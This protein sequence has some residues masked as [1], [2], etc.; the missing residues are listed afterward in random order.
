MQQI[1]AS[2]LT[3]SAKVFPFWFKCRLAVKDLIRYM[4]NRGFVKCN[5]NI[6]ETKT[7]QIC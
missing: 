7:R 1:V 4:G 2:L 3:T 5:M 6:S